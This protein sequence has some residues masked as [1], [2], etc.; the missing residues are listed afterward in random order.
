MGKDK[1]QKHII[2]K[3]DWRLTGQEKY[4]Q[5][6]ILTWQKYKMPRPRWDHDH[7]E[8]CGIKFIEQLDNEILNEGYSTKD[9]H[10]WICKNYFL[11]FQEMFHMCGV[12]II[13]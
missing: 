2:N 9:K 4:L 7:C 5:N 8:F 3:T 12:Q 13:I 6:A 10:H 11:D 1:P